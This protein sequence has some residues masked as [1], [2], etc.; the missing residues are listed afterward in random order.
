[1]NQNIW[2]SSMWFSL[3][4]ITMNYPNFPT[5][6]DRND[7]KLFFESLQNVIP[8]AVCKKNYKRHLK[9]KPINKHLN[10]RKEIVYWLIDMHNLVNAEIG[11]KQMSYDAVIRKYEDIYNKKILSPTIVEGYSNYYQVSNKYIYYIFFLMIILLLC[12]L[13]K[14]CKNSSKMSLKL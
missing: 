5:N 2:G 1:M 13:Y 9:E 10:T 7:Y 14:N 8:C 4:T 3:H 11:K 12:L 6:Q